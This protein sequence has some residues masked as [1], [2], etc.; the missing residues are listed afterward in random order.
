[1]G[2]AT[3]GRLNNGVPQI[4]PAKSPSATF[5][6]S[7][8]I[9]QMQDVITKAINENRIIIVSGETG[10]GKT[11]QVSVV[12]NVVPLSMSSDIY[13]VLMRKNSLVYEMQLMV[14]I[15]LI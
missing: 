14:C 9:Y 6:Q 7:L 12:M 3:T 8:P 11:T 2:K 4:P 1:M 5:Q 13:F 10:S 15:K